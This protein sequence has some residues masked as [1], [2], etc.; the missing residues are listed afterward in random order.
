[1]E[2]IKLVAKERKIAKNVVYAEYHRRNL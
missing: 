2:A 1:M